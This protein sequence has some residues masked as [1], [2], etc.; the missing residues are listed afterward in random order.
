MTYW[1]AGSSLGLLTCLGYFAFAFGAIHLRRHRQE[2]SFWMDDEVSSLRR[3]FSR[4][5]SVGPFYVP[6]TQSRLRVVP[7]GVLQS[8]S[9]FPKRHFSR[10]AFFLVLG[11]SLFFLDFF[12]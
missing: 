9:Q 1:G 12:I 3:N 5:E 6:R 2:I 4:Y 7:Q 8:V 11:F 10:G